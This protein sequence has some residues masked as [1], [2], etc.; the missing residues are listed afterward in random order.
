MEEKERAVKNLTWM[1]MN[2]IIRN[3]SKVETAKFID[4]LTNSQNVV[5]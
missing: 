2:S 1:L 5:Y 3:H 4:G